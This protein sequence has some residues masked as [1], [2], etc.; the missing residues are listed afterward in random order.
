VVFSKS[1]DLDLIVDRSWFAERFAGH[2]LFVI[3]AGR[4]LAHEMVVAGRALV[5]G[6]VVAGRVLVHEMVVAGLVL[7]HEAVV[8]GSLVPWIS[9]VVVLETYGHVLAIEIFRC[10]HDFVEGVQCL[11]YELVPNFEAGGFVVALFASDP[12]VASSSADPRQALLFVRRPE[13]NPRPLPS[14]SCRVSVFLCCGR[15]CST[16]FQQAPRRFLTY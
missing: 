7:V 12:S 9:C 2:D 15:C 8:V 14:S 10:L 5:Y 16:E 11:P 1:P 13:S 6:M 3:D 4:A